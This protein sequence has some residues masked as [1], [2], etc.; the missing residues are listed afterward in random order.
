MNNES[1][2]KV[3]DCIL[4]YKHGNVSAP[5][6]RL[7]VDFRQVPLDKVGRLHTVCW[8][9]SSTGSWLDVVK[10]LTYSLHYNV[11]GT[12]NCSAVLLG[13]NFLTL[14]LVVA[15]DYMEDARA[16]VARYLDSYDINC[17]FVHQ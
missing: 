8:N 2:A 13:E 16:C 7:I 6:Q 15:T 11:I 12:T 9:T 10:W 5:T 1:R 14:E 4:A 3:E 17:E